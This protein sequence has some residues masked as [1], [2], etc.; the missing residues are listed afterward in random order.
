MTPRAALSL[1]AAVLIW[2]ALVATGLFTRPLLPIDETRYLAV[3]WEMWHSGDYLVPHLDGIPY[4][5]KPPLLFW[6]IDLGWQVGGVSETWGRLVAPLFA[7]GSLLLTARLGA[8]LFPNAP[9]VAGLAPLVLVG[10]AFFALFSSLT[11]FD[12]LVT[13]FTLLGLIGVWQAAQGRTHRGWAVFAVALGLGVLSKGP[14]QLLNLATVP[15]LAPWWAPQRPASWRHWYGEFIFAVIVGAV[16]ALAWAIPAA[17]AGGSNFAYMLFI[18]QTTERVVEALW[19]ERPWW[20]YVPVSFALVFPWLWWPAWWRSL[21]VRGLLRE[22]GVRFCL[23][24]I[25]PIFL[26]FSAISGKQPHYLLPMI[27]VFSLLVARFVMEA[28][29]LERFGDSRLFR[30]PPLVVTVAAGVALIGLALFHGAIVALAPNAAEIPPLG[31]P[32]AA[33]G[34][35]VV[36]VGLLIGLG[37]A[38]GPALRIGSYSVATAAVLV[39]A[40]VAASP[41]LQ[42]RFDVGAVS[43]VVAKAQ[44]EDRPIANV[45]DYHGQYIFAGRLTKP[46]DVIQRE[47]VAAWAASHPSGIVITYPETGPASGPAE[48]VLVHPYRGRFVVIWQAEDVVTYGPD[49]LEGKA[50]SAAP[51]PAAAAPEAPP[52][53]APA[54][55]DNP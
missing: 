17:I 40:S 33:A 51:P 20:W 10:G 25:V 54:S 52:E 29:A 44:G 50:V 43:A 5:H 34:L 48:P 3:A 16:I 23:S 13:F 7:L 22:P 38:G 45:G 28:A 49:L 6:L 36:A 30:L 24:M 12:M 27:P 39:A 1:A 35:G 26:A 32:A 8:L 47:D 4:H 9:N 53:A 2:A 19:H 11:F 55:A 15:L 37:P 14:V 31:W 21:F 42:T 41:L 46:I 18:G